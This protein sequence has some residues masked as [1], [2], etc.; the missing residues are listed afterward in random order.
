MSWRYITFDSSCLLGGPARTMSLA[1]NMRSAA[2]P[3]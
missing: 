3:T 1:E 2:V